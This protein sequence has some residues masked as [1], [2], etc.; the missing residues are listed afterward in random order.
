MYDPNHLASNEYNTNYVEIV[1]IAEKTDF[2]V[3]IGN[4][5]NQTYL[6]HLNP[7]PNG[8]SE[9]WGT[10]RFVAN[11][12]GNGVI[13]VYVVNEL[14]VPNSTVNNDIEI[15]VYVSMGDD[16]EVAVPDDKFQRFVTKPFVALDAQSGEEENTELNSDVD[17]PFQES[18]STIGPTL[19]PLRDITSVY[20]GE[21]I[22]SFRPLL[23]RYVLHE[24]IGTQDSSASKVLSG[25]RSFY[26]YYRGGLSS[27][28]HTSGISPYNYVNTL[29][30]HWIN[31]AHCGFRGG[32]RYKIIPRGN[33]TEGLP[34]IGEVE[35]Y[36]FNDAGPQYNTTVLNVDFYTTPSA[37][38]RAAV[39]GNKL[40]A[41][42]QDNL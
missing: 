41:P 19:D 32:M 31:A 15:N 28:V 38:A 16:F 34:S 1:D 23:K 33:R 40:A 8:K 5:Q 25:T 22:R 7:G 6:E 35:R 26:P 42:I 21:T 13:G 10:S 12:V 29:L 4:G 39:L 17:M 36:N 20:F 11:E 14:T 9:M 37:A 27:A 30:V 3:T 2:T 18:S 24:C